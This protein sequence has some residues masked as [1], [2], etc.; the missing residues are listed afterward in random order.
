[1][2]SDDKKSIMAK[3]NK[4]KNS[5]AK[6][7]DFVQDIEDL[8]SGRTQEKVAEEGEEV[9]PEP[10][11]Q[12][13]A[14]VQEQEKPQEDTVGGSPVALSYLLEGGKGSILSTG[15]LLHAISAAFPIATQ[16]LENVRSKYLSSIS[17]DPSKQ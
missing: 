8:Y 16:E 4:W 3:I 17:D 15:Y 5:E 13:P 1:M 6:E 10:L 2:S 9:T 7:D 11:K 14:P 12:E